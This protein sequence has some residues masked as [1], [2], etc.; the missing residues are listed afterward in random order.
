VTAVNR[1]TKPRWLLL[2]A[3][4][5]GGGKEGASARF[6]FNDFV[7]SPSITKPLDYIVICA[8]HE[9]QHGLSQILYK[10][11]QFIY[12]NLGM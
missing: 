11:L 6:L 7:S 10:C 8:G 2:S 3:T 12:R 1:V 9:L 5:V 4:G